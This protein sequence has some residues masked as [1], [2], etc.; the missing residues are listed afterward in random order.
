MK[1]SILSRYQFFQN[2]SV[3][4]IQSQ[5]IAQQAFFFFV[6]NGSLIF[7]FI[8]ECERLKMAKAIKNKKIKLEKF[9]YV[10]SR[11]IMELQLSRQYWYMNKHI[12]LIE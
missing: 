5:P 7:K 4:S 6:V 10:T 2:Q 11:F 1:D 9:Y 8:K 3:D 12:R